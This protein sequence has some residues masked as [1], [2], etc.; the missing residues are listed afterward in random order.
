MSHRIR[1]NKDNAF[2]PNAY[3]TLGAGNGQF[4]DFGE[5]V[6]DSISKQ[7]PQDAPPLD[8]PLHRLKK[9]AQKTLDSEPYK[10]LPAMA[11]C[12]RL[13]LLL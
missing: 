3:I 13:D 10:G 5:M 7:G 4:R 11:R 1:I 8:S 2:F 6:R 12:I 9:N